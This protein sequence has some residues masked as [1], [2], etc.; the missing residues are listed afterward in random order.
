MAVSRWVYR[1]ADGVFL[2]GGFYDAQPLDASAGVVEF[3]DADPHPDPRLQR[4]DAALGKRPATPQEIADYD[5]ARKDAAAVDDVDDNKALSA[6][7]RV[8][9][10]YLP[11]GKPTLAAFA[12]E[13]KAL[14]KTL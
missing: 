11:A 13:V 7:A 10:K 8:T 1:K 6:L 4:F 2:F 12:A 9:H 3:S 14:Y 5:A